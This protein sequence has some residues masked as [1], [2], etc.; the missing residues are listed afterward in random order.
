MTESNMVNSLRVKVIVLYPQSQRCD[1]ETSVYDIHKSE[2]AEMLQR[3]EN[4]ELSE[5]TRQ[6]KLRQGL[7][8]RGMGPDKF[9]GTREFSSSII[10]G[11]NDRN[12]RE[13]KDGKGGRKQRAHEVDPKHHL[14]TCDLVAAEDFVLGRIGRSVESEVYQEINDTNETG[15][16]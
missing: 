4:E 9:K 2:G 8:N 12:I 5:S 15:V 14:L 7:D 1:G 11:M 10:R 3:L 13:R 6:C 16:G